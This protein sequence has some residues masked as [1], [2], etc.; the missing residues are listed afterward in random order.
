MKAGP[1]SYRKKEHLLITLTKFSIKYLLPLAAIIFIFFTA[2][3][4]IENND[5]QIP[6]KEVSVRVDTK[7]VINNE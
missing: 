6:Q 7:N 2:F 4:L 1:K 5:I 3:D